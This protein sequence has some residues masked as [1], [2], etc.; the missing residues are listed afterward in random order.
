MK[1]LKLIIKLVKNKPTY[2]LFSYIT[3]Q[4]VSLFPIA[5]GLLIREI[6]KCYE[7]SKSGITVWW[8]IGFFIATLMGRIVVVYFNSIAIAKARFAS[9]SLIRV[10]LLN[11]IMEKPGAKKLNKF[12]GDTLNSFRDDVNMIEDFVASSA[13]E[14]MSI[15]VFSSVSLIIL[16]KI[17]YKITLFIFAPMII[18]II[19][20]RLVGKKITKYRKDNRKATGYVSSAI[21]EMFTNIQSIKVFGVEDSIKANFI[22]L[23]K[24]REKYAIKDNMLTQLLSTTFDNILNI[25]TGLILLVIA[26]SIKSGNFNLGDFTLF[27]YYMNFISYFIQLFGNVVTMY[28]QTIVSFNNITDIGDDISMKDLVVNTKIDIKKQISRMEEENI[29]EEK[30][31]LKTLEFKNITYLYPE[32]NSGIE[33][34]SFK[35]EK[36]T[37]TVIAGRVGSGKTTLLRV[38]LGLLGHQEGKLYWNDKPVNKPEEFFIPPRVAYSPQIPHFFSAT[39]EENILLGK[40]KSKLDVKKAI[41]L[42]VM[43]KDIDKFQEGIKTLIGTNGVKLSGGQQQRLSA[44]RMFV[45][46]AELFVFD[47][48][49]SALDIETEEILW[50]RL[51]EENAI[52]CI[53]VSNRRLAL[54]KAD[55]IILIK[56]GKLDSQGKLEELLKKSKEMRLIWG[57]NE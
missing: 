17:N 26:S 33:D 42:A 43:D 55:N 11:K 27:T 36:N 25:G 29:L 13:V 48:I 49:S 44:A 5:T 1:N 30:D 31:K 52:T 28:K 35:I 47:D 57:E 56:D 21:D 14:F 41:N 18:V 23:N 16:F 39:V 24:E 38:M 45:Q 3:Y 15:L 2:F 40:N 20:L 6:F 4:L 37:F 10:N 34:V 19:I 7:K 12:N 46:N 32:T 9:S 53:A 22:T 54:K 51:F 8:L 50:A